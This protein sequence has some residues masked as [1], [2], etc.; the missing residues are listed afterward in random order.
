VQYLY[1]TPNCAHICP[2]LI[3]CAMGIYFPLERNITF[4][5]FKNKL[6]KYVIIRLHNLKLD[7]VIVLHVLLSMFYFQL[8]L[9]FLLSSVLLPG[10]ILPGYL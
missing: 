4:I 3:D 9:G 10:A 7:T 8:F 1:L 6:R 5:F 2:W